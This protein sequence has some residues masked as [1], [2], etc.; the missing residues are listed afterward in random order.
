MCVVLHVSHV[1]KR[2]DQDDIEEL[3]RQGKLKYHQVMQVKEE[4][5]YQE[6]VVAKFKLDRVNVEKEVAQLEV[7]G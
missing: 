6:A 1:R 2:T 4:F 7:I 3:K 5:S